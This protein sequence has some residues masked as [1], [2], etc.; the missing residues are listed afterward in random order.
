V[1]RVRRTA[2]LL[3]ALLCAAGSGVATAVAAHAD[4]G[5]ARD[6]TRPVFRIGDERVSESSGLAVSRTHPGL[7]YT[8]NDSGDDARV[9]VV[10]LRDG[11]VVGQT[12]LRGVEAD[13]FE[14]LA[15]APG[16]RLVVADIGD[17]DA[18]RDSVEL[19]VLPEPGPGPAAVSPRT[20]ALTY[21]G[22]AHDAEAVVVV[23]PRVFVVT[24][25]VFGGVYSAPVFGRP[26]SGRTPATYPLRRVAA[27][28]S[29]VTDAT[30]LAGGDVVLRDYDRGYLVD[31]PRWRVRGSFPLPSV[32]QGETVAAPPGARRVYA[33]SEGVDS[34]VY[35][36]RVPTAAQLPAGPAASGGTG[37]DTT[38]QPAT[39]P[40]ERPDLAGEQDRPRARPPGYIVAVAAALVAG[41][42]LRRWRRRHRR[43]PIQIR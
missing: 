13:D 14:A 19:Y 34:P 42:L 15:P 33:G 2:S 37:A 10:S 38:G 32:A 18:E 29:V 28:P 21:P 36:V 16:G 25:E 12:L 30:R 4:D 17:N 22:G 7:A 6:A 20:V 8:V 5:G 23:R 43:P 11:A 39:G 27:A 41:F 26:G 35:L 31:L 24:K 1:S 9:L 3:A 40:Q